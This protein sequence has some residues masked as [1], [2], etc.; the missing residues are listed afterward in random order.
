[1]TFKSLFIIAGLLFSVCL[2]SAALA[3]QDDPVSI[4][5]D[6]M[7][8]DDAARKLVFAGNAVARQGD[9]SITS[10]RLTIE[11]SADNRELQ[12]IVAVGNVHIEQGGR[13][14]TGG[15]AVYDK[16]EGRIVLTGD[17]VVKEGPNSVSGNEI[18]LFLNGKRSLVTGTGESRVRAVFQPGSGDA[19]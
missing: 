11:Y 17:P 6:R 8:A 9:V 3:Q 15:H 4:T 7:E 16:R 14:A 10:D 12:Q 5:A 13:V 18:T 19:P 2:P 1:M